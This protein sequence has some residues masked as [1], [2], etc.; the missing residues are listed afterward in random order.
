MYIYYI[1]IIISQHTYACI[2]VYVSFCA[3]THINVKHL[4]GND[5]K[6]TQTQYASGNFIPNFCWLFHILKE[7]QIYLLPKPSLYLKCEVTHSGFS[8]T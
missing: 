7:K 3:C 8:C 2:C 6:N 5:Q 1:H 4:G